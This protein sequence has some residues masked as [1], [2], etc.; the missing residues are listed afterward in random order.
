MLNMLKNEH[1]FLGLSE[2]SSLQQVFRD[3]INDYNKFF[4]GE[5][6]YPKFKSKKHTKRS[7]RIQNNHNI[8]IRNNTIFLPKLGEIITEQ[9]KNIMKN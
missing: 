3:L 8:K 4:K 5:G 7:F 9:V 2:S 1:D 6:G